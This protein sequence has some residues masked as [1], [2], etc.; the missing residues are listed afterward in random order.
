MI[1]ARTDRCRDPARR[2]TAGA[3]TALTTTVTRVWGRN[4]SPAFSAVWRG[5]RCKY[6]DRNYHIGISAA[7]GD[8]RDHVADRDRT[9]RHD[10]ARHRRCRPGPALIPDTDESRLQMR[11]RQSYSALALV[12]EVIAERL[13]HDYRRLPETLANLL[14]A[15]ASPK[16]ETRRSG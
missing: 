11:V 8:E 12:G 15:T 4:P 2:R 14:V 1:T 6:S 13:R 10:A 7:P 9:D 5:T 3:T 16:P